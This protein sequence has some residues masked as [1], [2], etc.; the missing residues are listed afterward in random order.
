MTDLHTWLIVAVVA[1][2]TALLRF[3]PFVVFN[4]NPARRP[5]G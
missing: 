4:D 2:V 3:L 5:G 1:L